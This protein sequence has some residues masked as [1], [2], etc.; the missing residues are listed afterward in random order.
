M[1]INAVAGSVILYLEHDFYNIIFK[2]KHKLYIASGSA[3]LPTKGKIEG[4]R[5]PAD[6]SLIQHVQTGCGAHPTSCS[7]GA[8]HSFPEVKRP[9]R[10]VGSFICI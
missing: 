10:E 1:Y 6:L 4:A 5:L 8:G 2:I 7:V 3:L 9:G